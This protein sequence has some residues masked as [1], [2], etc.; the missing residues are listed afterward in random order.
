[1]G[2]ALLS[3]LSVSALGSLPPCALFSRRRGPGPR[4]WAA[5]TVTSSVAVLVA[6]AA[7]GATEMPLE[8]KAHG[9]AAPSVMPS[10][11]SVRFCDGEGHMPLVE[12][13]VPIWLTLVGGLALGFHPTG[14]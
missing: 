9:S 10:W 13:A 6:K 5:P 14:S 8:S 7:A 3:F 1:V 12:A 2:G 11:P 4:A